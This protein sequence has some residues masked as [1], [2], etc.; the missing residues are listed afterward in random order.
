MWRIV[1]ISIWWLFLAVATMIVETVFGAVPLWLMVLAAVG[2]GCAAVPLM[3]GRDRRLTRVSCFYVPIRDAIRHVIHTTPHSYQNAQMAADHF[4]DVLYEQ[5]CSGK[6][7]VVGRKGEDGELKPINKRDCKRHTPSQVVVPPN[8]S[9][10]E[11]VRYC[12]VD[13]TRSL[14]RSP[15]QEVAFDGFTDLRVRSRDLYRRWPKTE[16]GNDNA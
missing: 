9:A 3:F 10:P 14:T 15:L 13:R 2:L 11:G 6:I 16:G 8:P 5:M 12:L 4:F 7:G 1:G